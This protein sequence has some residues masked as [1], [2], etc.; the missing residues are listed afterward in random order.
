M[1]YMYGNINR[2]EVNDLVQIPKNEY[3]EL[4][5]DSK[6]LA[7]LRSAGVDNWDGYDFAIEIFE[8]G[9]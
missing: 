5:E 9:L 1:Y 8:S 3:D 4:L 7:A 6:F 2:F